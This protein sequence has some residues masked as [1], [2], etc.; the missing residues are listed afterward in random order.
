MKRNKILLNENVQHVISDHIEIKVKVDFK[1]A[2]ILYNTSHLFNLPRLS[3]LLLPINIRC[4]PIVCDRDFSELEL[5]PAVKMLSNNGLN[6]DSELVVFKAALT[7]L[8][9]Y[10]QRS[11]HAKRL[12]R[13][14]RFSLLSAREIKHAVGKNLCNEVF[15]A[16]KEILSAKKKQSCL[17]KFKTLMRFCSD[18][19]IVLC[20]GVY[21]SSRVVTNEVCR[22]KLNEDDSFSALPPMTISRESP[23]VVHLKDAIYVFG[24]SN[25]SEDNVQSVEK[26]SLITKSWE[27][28]TE[29]YDDRDHYDVT[30]HMDSI[31]VIGSRRHRYH[32]SLNPKTRTWKVISATHELGLNKA[33]AVFQGRVVVSGGFVVENNVNE[34]LRNVEEYDV[35]NNA[36]S[37]TGRMIGAREGHQMAAV[38]SKLFFIGGHEETCEVYDSKSDKFTLV[39]LPEEF[40]D[41]FIYPTGVVSVGDTLVVFGDEQKEVLFFDAKQ[42]EW[43]HEDLEIFKNLSGFGC[44]KVPRLL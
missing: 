32:L 20:G 16:V 39:R 28:I 37:V 36:W 9:Q 14:I 43:S 23:K 12:L 6:V 40:S 25:S 8:N 34:T 13:H 17:P 31:Y 3:K 15:H 24:G 26:Y 22:Y 11:K 21:I 18:F 1:N 2:A 35:I 19:D 10:E 44:T 41:H 42:N 7:W 4:F 30:A 38:R 33:S 27:K 29:M 5:V